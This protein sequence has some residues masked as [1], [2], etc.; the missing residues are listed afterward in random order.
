M[1]FIIIL[2]VVLIISL[3]IYMIY[4][5][6]KLIKL[7]IIIQKEYSNIH[8]N[9]V[10]MKAFLQNVS[11]RKTCYNCKFKT[12]NRNSDIT[13]GDLWGIKNILPD[14]T[15]DKGVSVV[16]IQSEKG[17]RLFEQ[18][19]KELWIQEISFDSAIA[20]NSAMTKSVYEHNFRG[21]FFKN[22]GK[23]NFERLVRDCLEPS[24]YVRLKR[25]LNNILSK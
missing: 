2:L 5:Y 14:I 6:N 23:Q 25:K 13:M 4:L 19:N 10:F 17:N 18:V 12:V 9:D 22:L 21:Y 1:I 8:Y 11:L 7:E 15:D 20:S 16:F 24:Y 3:S